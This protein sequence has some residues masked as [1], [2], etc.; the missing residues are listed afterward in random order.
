MTTRTIHGSAVALLQLAGAVEAPSGSQI[1]GVIAAGPAIPAGAFGDE[2]KTGY[3]LAA[4]AGIALRNSPIEI[5]GLVHYG[6]FGQSPGEGSSKPLAVTADASLRL[7]PQ[8]A[9][10]RP[11]LVGGVG[12]H[13]FK[14]STGYSIP[15]GGEGGGFSER[16]S[17]PSV[18]GGAGLLFGTGGARVFVEA[19]Y[20]AI[21]GSDHNHLPIAVGLRLGR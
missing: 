9:K 21:T 10:V 15:G 4:G 6:S 5:R 1:F 11:Y 16:D 3:D 8:E 20:V 17:S 13:S 14:Y 12:F 19:R 18:G 7:G 2:F